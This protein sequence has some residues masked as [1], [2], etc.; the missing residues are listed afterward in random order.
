MAVRKEPL[1]FAGTVLL[2]GWLAWSSRS[3]GAGRVSRGQRADPPELEHHPAPDP[4]IVLPST[5]VTDDR[6]PRDLFSPPSDTRP[7]PPLELEPL[8]RAPLAMLLPPPEPGPGPALYG[9]F[10]RVKPYRVPAPNLFEAGAEPEVEA[11]EAADDSAAG[12]KPSEL[13]PEEKA[14]RI[15]GLKKL[16]DWVRTVEFKFGQIKNPNRYQLSRRPGEDIL[17][18]EF[19]PA[20][21]LPRLAKQGPV[22]IS[23]SLVAEF[24]FA[25]TV[26]NQVEKRRAEFEDPLSASQY[27]GALSFADW[28]VEQRLETPRALEVAEEMYR[29]AMPV[30]AEDAAPHLGLARCYEAGFEFEKAFQEYRALLQGVHERDPVVLSRLAGLEAR[31]RLFREADE[32]FAEAERYGRSQWMVQHAY[33]SYLFE[34][35]RTQ[36]AV[37]HLRLASQYEPAGAERKHERARIRV[38]LAAALLRAGDVRGSAE[39]FEKGRQA[40]PADQRALA[41]ALCAASILSASSGTSGAPRSGPGN[42]SGGSAGSS[43]ASSPDL[44]GVGF[45]LLLASGVEAIGHRDAESAERARAN[46]QLAAAVDPLRAHLAWRALS[47]LAEVTGHPEEALRFAEQAVENAP[48]DA[49][50]LYHRG[51]LLAER[52]DLDGAMQ[53]FSRALEVELD[54]PDA[55]AAMGEIQNRRGDYAAAERYLERALALDPGLANVAALRGVNFLGLSSLRDA[56]ASF[57]AARAITPDEPTA[58]SGLAWCR[59]LVG[60]VVEA[61]TRLRELDDA[62]RALPE[63]DPHRVWARAQIARIQDH[64]E[65]VVWSDRFERT[66]LRM[67]WER[68]ERAGPQFSI[69]DGLVTLGGVFKADGRARGWQV[70]SASAFVALEARITIRSGTTARVGI[71]VSR[72]TARAGE[73]QVEAEVTLS[74]HPDAGANTIQTRV[75]KRGEEDLAYTDVAGFDWK[76]DTPVLVRIE[77]TGESSDTRVRLLVDGFPVLD[78]KAVPN[79]GRTTSELRLGVFAEGKTGRQVHIDID[80]VEI[81]YRAK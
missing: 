29:R 53:S 4:S 70:R 65:K 47:F 33:G 76:L 73:T 2:L 46:L 14:Q 61:L 25:D 39:W 52:D 59:Y 68:D 58:W 21:G 78:G 30:L 23:R 22:P 54:F 62:R 7:L 80:D 37:E 81:V 45:D 55:L 32:H 5:R 38:D 10:L 69:H 75:M 49:Y 50:A 17:F 40:D 71:F 18:V 28:C 13:T 60:D 11:P 27:E 64:V 36:A 51:R 8:P 12:I 44:T 42:G 34:R 67:G 63:D 20:T 48:D 74:R 43:A 3:E 31:F 57:Q 26:L 41:G 24:D 72:E 79:L 66:D 16:Y 1:V 56:E 77:R 9:R 19:N 35:G 15:S 6:R